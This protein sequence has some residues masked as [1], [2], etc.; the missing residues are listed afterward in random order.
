MDREELPGVTCASA[1]R[2]PCPQTL[3]QQT[4]PP[5]PVPL[6]HSHS[7]RLPQGPPDTPRVDAS[8]TPRAPQILP[9][10]TPP[11]GAPRHS[12]SRRYPA[13]LRGTPDTP[14]VDATRH[15][16]ISLHEQDFWSL[17][18]MLRA[19]SCRPT[20]QWVND[21]PPLS[22][23]QRHMFVPSEP[24]QGARQCRA[25]SDPRPGQSMAGRLVAVRMEGDI[26]APACSSPAQRLTSREKQFNKN[27]KIHST[28]KVI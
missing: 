23:A 26:A 27:Q 17:Q 6:R 5:P 10:Q 3:P 15:P 7:R 1:G 28:G 20:S 16:G 19:L 2:A 14:R 9:E 8:P 18:E 12:H 13:T 25:G 21:Q 11:P 4:P 24:V 22:G